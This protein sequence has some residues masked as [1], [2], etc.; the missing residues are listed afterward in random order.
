MKLD[1]IEFL[2]LS[3]DIINKA[4]LLRF[5]ARGKS[6]C[7]SILDGDILTVERAAADKIRLG[8]V[9]FYKTPDKRLAAHRFIKRRLREGKLILIA[10]GDS[11]IEPE[12]VA[13]GD[14]LGKVKFIQRGDRRIFPDSPLFKAIALFY[15][16]INFAVEAMRKIAG[17]LLRW[18]QGFK[19][20]R[21]IVRTLIRVKVNYEIESLDG[22][23]K[24]ILAKRED[25]VIAGLNL[26]N[27]TDNEA[28]RGWWIYSTQVHWFYRRLGIAYKLT[29]TAL[30][31]L[32]EEGATQVRLF[33]FKDNKPAV[34]LYSK[35]GFNQVSVP[36][37]DRELRR[38]DRK[39]KKER[40]IMSKV[41]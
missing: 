25:K 14:L 40:I 34:N 29:Y 26:N 13:S 24:R 18:V 23:D 3:R 39:T 16:R 38:G 4:G 5:K 1:K 6:M 19:V 9:I 36:A 8:E 22:L 12:E 37:I 30:R 41:L 2:K 32:K 20:Y 27:F 21:Y 33:V 28:Y 35:L 31:F 17:M 7:P 11:N 10:R 15:A